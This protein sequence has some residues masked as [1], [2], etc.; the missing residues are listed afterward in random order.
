MEI[1]IKIKHHRSY[2]LFFMGMIL[3]LLFTGCNKQQAKEIPSDCRLTFYNT[4]KSDSILIEIEG[5][6]LL[7]DTADEDDYQ[8]IQKSLEEKKI[9]KIDYMIISHF[10]KDHIGSAAKIIENNDIGCVLMPDYWENSEYYQNMITAIQNKGIERKV[11][12]EDYS[13]TTT[14]GSITISA[15]HENSYKDENNFSLITTVSYEN[16]SFLLMGDALKTRTEEFLAD[17]ALT[18]G[19]YDVIKLPHHGDYNKKLKSLMDTVKPQFAVITVDASEER[20]EDK[21][22]SLLE[23]SVG[24]AFYTYDGEIVAT[25]DGNIVNITQK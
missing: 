18:E 12:D 24:E 6:V 23:E 10:D 22:R 4:G 25:S 15:P 19:E 17:T 7:N 16:T 20:V 8:M 2:N 11:L 13:I 5:M 1:N 9:E 21:L 14:N 3:I